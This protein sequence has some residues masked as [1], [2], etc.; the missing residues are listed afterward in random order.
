MSVAVA[1]CFFAAFVAAALWVP[2]DQQAIRRHVVAAVGDGTFN[3]R[4]PYGPFGRVVWPR[5]TLDC[6]LAG[7]MLAP[8]GG[9]LIDALSNQ[10]IV[11]NVAWQDPRVPETVDCQA[12]LRAIPELG[13]GYG[14]ITRQATD[15]Y[16][17]GVR[18]IG[19][20][21]LGLMPF[22]AMAQLLR[23]IAFAL[24]A[25]LALLS[26]AKLRATMR[27]GEPLLRPAGYLVIAA[28]L[29]CLYGVHYFDAM[30][31][32][33]PP[34]HTHFIFIIVSLLVPL[35]RMRPAG[36]AVYAASYGSLIAIFESLTG[37]IPFA[38]AMLPLLLAL[39][40]DGTRRDYL[41]RL[42]VLWGSF[43]VAVA[44]C[45]AIKKGLTAAFLN[46][47]ESFVSLLL[48]RM[49]GAPMPE[50]GT[51]LTLGHLLS[52]YRR[53]AS[54]I[55]LGSTNIGTGL[56]VAAL[57]IFVAATWRA[58]NAQR[59][60]PILIACWLGIAV[61]ILWAAAFLNHT[62]IHAYFMARLFVI[63]VIG[64]SLLVLARFVPARGTRAA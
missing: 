38:L 61:F 46:D 40:F 47:Q 7:M 2:Q 29:S 43:C 51:K 49:Y 31:Y 41:T 11:P 19:K 39:G 59:E 22:D 25:V 14:D 48:Y 8:P 27:A 17:L 57:G 50:S 15:R 13:D 55:A 12:M 16:I 6:A 4:L 5:H 3:V 21:L 10:F 45:F 9:R 18:V 33:A 35:G 60:C 63:P 24:L 58:R 64:A 62:A 56:V 1:A 53:W 34:D 23:A 30:L 44:T 37:G 36:L 28:L 52:A 42:V 54:L 26:F 20:I 32:F